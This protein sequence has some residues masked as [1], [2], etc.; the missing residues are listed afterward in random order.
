[1][2]RKALQLELKDLS[3]EKRTATIA[4]A[5]YDNIDRT[6]DISR[7]GMFNASWAES[8]SDISFYLNH[9]DEK[10]PG[11]VLDV[12]EDEKKAYT[13][14]YLGN[15]TL[16]NDTLIMMDEG[17]IKSASF[18]Y[19]TVKKEMKQHNGRSIREL[20]EVK[21]NETS[22]LTK[23]PA[24]PLAG[25][26]SVTKSLFPAKES[27]SLTQSEFD[28]LKILAAHDQENLTMLIN[29]SARLDSSSDLYNWILW[30]ISR[31]ADVMGSIRSQLQYNAGELKE[32]NQHI[33]IME[34]FV[35][36]TKASDDCIKSVQ[37]QID[38]AKQILSVYDVD[39]QKASDS[40]ASSQNSNDA[41]MKQ[42]LLFKTQ[43]AV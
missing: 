43:L 21:H 10:V 33:E 9:D 40:K 38:E 11:K 16:G 1:M 12:Y 20:K 2:E 18:G 26:I 23:L 17:V 22:V 5:V 36:D 7:K 37:S 27:K 15:H 32:F 29:L 24:N 4:H 34:K 35:R 13:N 42:I 19:I 28:M 14:V 31:R 3:K 41:L 30:Q 6:G 39:G 8:K 25:V